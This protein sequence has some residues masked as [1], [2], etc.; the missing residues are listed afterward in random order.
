MME[1]KT[2]KISE[3]KQNK[4]TTAGAELTQT[5][6][7]I[8]ERQTNINRYS[9]KLSDALLKIDKAISN[10]KISRDFEFLDTEPFYTKE[11]KEDELES[12]TEAGY[13]LIKDGELKTK[14]YKYTI[15]NDGYEEEWNIQQLPR[16]ERKAIIQS[17]RLIKFLTTVAEQLAVAEQ[18][19]K[20]VAEIAEKM[21]NAIQ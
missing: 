13:L 5:I 10:I 9:D 16:L 18:E 17:G 1:V 12:P 8:T 19:Y 3:E 2:Q 15:Y 4:S 21:A 11:Y 14:Y 6:N 20:Q 7:Y